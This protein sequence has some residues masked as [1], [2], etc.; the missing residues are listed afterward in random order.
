M[1]NTIDITHL[2]KDKSVA[3]QFMAIV[4]DVV[5]V[6]EA[7]SGHLVLPDEAVSALARLRALVERGLAHD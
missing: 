2:Q 7:T 3:D 4:K 6:L 5:T 1:D